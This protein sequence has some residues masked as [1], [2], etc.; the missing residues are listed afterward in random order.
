MAH[1]TSYDL[2]VT[3]EDLADAIR[4]SMVH[5]NRTL[6]VLRAAGAVEFQSGKLTVSDRDELVEIAE[7]D[8]GCSH[9][10]Q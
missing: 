7:L 8:A 2:P 3:Q 10:H 9:H 4:M 6:M 1:D 5:V